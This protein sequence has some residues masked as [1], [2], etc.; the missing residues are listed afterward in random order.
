MLPN[1]LFADNE[2]VLGIGPLRVAGSGL[3]PLPLE[4]Y[5]RIPLVSGLMTPTNLGIVV[6][7]SS[8]D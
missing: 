3:P 1:E 2:D 7:F 6:G 4:L 5:E 8:K